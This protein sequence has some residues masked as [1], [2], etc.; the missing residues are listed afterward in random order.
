ML[1]ALFHAWERQLA[2]VTKDRV[3][4]P[5]DWGLDWIPQNGDAHAATS[6]AAVDVLSDWVSHVCGDTDAFFRPPPTTEYTLAPAADGDMLTFPS[7]FVT[8][9]K[10]N[11]TVYARYFRGSNGA[12]SSNRSRAAV[13]GLPQSNADPGAQLR[14]IKLVALNRIGRPRLTP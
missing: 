8:P 6:D 10:E 4:R 9:H 13:P 5:F 1:Q 14:L 2:D 3:V 7:A 11:N 12:R